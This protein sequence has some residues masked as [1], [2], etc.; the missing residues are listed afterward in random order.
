[1]SRGVHVRRRRAE[2]GTKGRAK[3]S[4]KPTA[5]SRSKGSAK[6]RARLSAAVRSKTRS[7]TRPK[8]REDQRATSRRSASPRIRR[9]RIPVV[10]GAVFA[11]AVIG[12]SFPFSTLLSQHR[13]LSAEAAQL[14]QVQSDNRLL[15]EQDRQLSSSAEV[16][17]LAREEYQLVLPGQ[18]LF[19]VLPPSGTSASTTQGDPANQSLVSPSNAPDMSPDPGLPRSAGSSAGAAG[20]DRPATGGAGPAASGG[21]GRA[22]SPPS[23]WSRV[24]G[25]LEFWK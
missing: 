8:T 14:R 11:L 20:S 1:M 22:S 7:K 10:L 4:A 12:T 19:D 15:A 6:P 17:R 9:N 25:T 2:D 21:Q 24:A 3:R 23:F 16:D 5:K 18:T 13:E